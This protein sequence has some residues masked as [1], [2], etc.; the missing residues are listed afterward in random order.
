MVEQETLEDRERQWVGRSGWEHGQM[1]TV[2]RSQLQFGV[3]RRI[4]APCTVLSPG[5]GAR[6]G[7]PEQV[8]LPGG[9]RCGES[10]ALKG[11]IFF[12]SSLY[13]SEMRRDKIIHALC[14]KSAKW[15]L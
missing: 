9:R 4:L 2:R 7:P 14:P 13:L 11:V 10:G 12:P 6:G 8:G 1:W 5:E 3:Y 15:M